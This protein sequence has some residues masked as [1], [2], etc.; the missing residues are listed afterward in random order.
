M[1]TPAFLRRLPF[2]SRLFGPPRRE[3]ACS[4]YPLTSELHTRA[5]EPSPPYLAPTSRWFGHPVEGYLPA[6][7]EPITPLPQGVHHVLRGRALGPDGIPVAPGDYVLS[8]HLWRSRAGR[9]PFEH[10][11]LSRRRRPYPSVKLKGRVALVSSNWSIGSYAH[12]CADALPRWPMLRASGLALSDFDHVLV[13]HP[14][15]AST[16]HLLNRSEFSARVVEADP[17]VDYACDELVF[18]SYPHLAPHFDQT[19]LRQVRDMLPARPPQR[20]VYLS[21]KGYPRHPANSPELEN[22]LHS[23]GFETV[24]AQDHHHALEACRQASVVVGVEGSNLFNILF[25]PPG[26]R[27]ITLLWPGCP[28]SYISTLC[29]ALGHAEA[30]VPASPSGTKSAP[31][32]NLSALTAALDWALQAT[33]N[34]P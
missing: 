10:L 4:G 22:L 28:F 14:R 33:P 23:C 16:R 13:Y 18:A 7:T 21:R 31:F 30:I 1:I 8:D 20:R 9:I 11:H 12:F 17:K 29:A 25:C 2:D 26:T 24:A 15:S 19:W 3:C 27:V 32:F 6:A 5:L 34:K